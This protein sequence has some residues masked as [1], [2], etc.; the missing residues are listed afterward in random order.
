[1]A[2]CLRVPFHKHGPTNVPATSTKALNA[3]LQQGISQ[4]WRPQF[5]EEALEREGAT[6][7]A[8]TRGA[9]W[10]SWRQGQDLRAAQPRVRRQ[11]G[12]A[13]GGA[14]IGDPARRASSRR[15]QVARSKEKN[16]GFYRKIIF[17]NLPQ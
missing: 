13:A 11:A 6:Q 14:A 2:A 7:E 5:Y 8:S 12:W 4:L 1:M 17:I 16:A 15:M 10:P 9:D 3:L